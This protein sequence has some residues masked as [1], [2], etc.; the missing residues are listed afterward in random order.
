MDSKIRKRKKIKK[1]SSS[2][3]AGRPTSP[4]FVINLIKTKVLQ[5]KKR[6]NTTS[7]NAFTRLTT[8]KGWEDLM[9]EYAKNKSPLQKKYFMDRMLNN[10]EAQTQ[11]YK[12]NIIKDRTGINS[13]VKTAKKN[14]I[15]HKK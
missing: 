13:L 3:S 7:W 9:L 11:F 10:K 12:D 6:Y 14:Y 8:H 1:Y 5:Y 15:R 4:S 2:G